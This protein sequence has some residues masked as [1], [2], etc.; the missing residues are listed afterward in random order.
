MK[1]VFRPIRKHNSDVLHG[2]LVAEFGE[3]FLAVN[4]GS[5]NGQPEF[6]FTVTDDFSEA[7]EETLDGI[8]EKHD[9]SKLTSRQQGDLKAKN[10]AA[11][12]REAFDV[13]AIYDDIAR[14]DQVGAISKL[15]Q[16]V[17]AISN[18][19]LN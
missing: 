1:Q 5:Y 12:I 17:E 9:S 11:W 13:Q 19:L 4:T 6:M 15:T 7:D 8:V 16:F 18:V 3:R 10:S 2:E 14:G